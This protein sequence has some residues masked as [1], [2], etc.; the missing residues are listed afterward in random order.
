MAV[1][2]VQV[3]MVALDALEHAMGHVEVAMIPA[4]EHVQ[5]DAQ[6]LVMEVVQAVVTL[7]AVHAQEL[8]LMDA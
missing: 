8:A 4:K 1:L 5:A 6:A 2:G 7:V 3:V